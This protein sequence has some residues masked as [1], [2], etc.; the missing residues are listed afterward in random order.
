[1]LVQAY[2]GKVKD[3][4]MHLLAKKNYKQEKTHPAATG[5][6]FKKQNKYSLN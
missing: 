1:M 2:S 5:Q 4:K 3:F 6:A